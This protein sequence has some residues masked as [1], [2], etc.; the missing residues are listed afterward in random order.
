MKSSPDLGI[1]STV[2]QNSHK[3]PPNPH[4]YDHAGTL[5]TK[6][7]HLPSASTQMRS[8]ATAVTDLQHLLNGGQ[9][10]DQERDTLCSGRTGPWMVRCPLETLQARYLHLLTPRKT[11]KSLKVTSAPHD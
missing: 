8:L 3:T 1:L 4:I 5:P 9:G 2:G 7:G 11:L 10:R 6:N